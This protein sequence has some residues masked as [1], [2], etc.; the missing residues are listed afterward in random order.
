MP[1]SRFFLE[2][3]V[4]G[5]PMGELAVCALPFR[6]LPPAPGHSG[7]FFYWGKYWLVRPFRSG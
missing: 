1:A 2:A 4:K 7:A 3:D 5:M 6:K